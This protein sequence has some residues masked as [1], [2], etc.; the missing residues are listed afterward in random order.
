[1]AP[2]GMWWA[3]VQEEERPKSPDFQRYLESIW[4]PE[5]GDRHQNLRVIGSGVTEDE[6]R[7]RLEACLLTDEELKVPEQWSTLVDPFP[8]PSAST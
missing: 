4:H 1:M 3:T 8:W 7:G 5:F 2:E 6:L